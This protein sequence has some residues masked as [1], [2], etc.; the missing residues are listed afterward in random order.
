MTA[1]LNSRLAGWFY[2]HTTASLGA[3]RPEVHQRQLLSLPFPMPEDLND[4]NK[5]RIAERRIVESINALLATK[6]SPLAASDWMTSYVDDTNQLV[7]D[8]YGLTADER[9]IVEDGVKEVV[10]S[11]QPHR[12]F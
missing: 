6:D 8:Y 11:V 9:A 1:V 12:G 10:P 4:P 5:A 2:F 3:E 7:Y